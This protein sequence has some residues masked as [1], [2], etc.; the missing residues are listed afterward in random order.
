LIALLWLASAPPLFA[1]QPE[2]FAVSELPVRGRVL[3]AFA[4]RD[5]DGRAWLA[6][7][8]AEAMPPDERRFLTLFARG[9]PAGAVAIPLRAAVAALD[10]AEIG[11]APGPEVVLL[12][13]AQ[14]R[15]L[16]ARGAPLRSIALAPPLPL[17]PRTRE[18]SRLE[19]VGAWSRPAA[20][21]ALLPDVAGF[22]LVSLAPGSGDSRALALPPS[23]IYGEPQPGPPVRP[24]F[25]RA[26]LSWPAVFAVDDDG[27][28]V[29]DLVATTRYAL[30]TYRSDAGGGLS[31]K[32]TRSRRFPPFSFEEERR[33]DSNLMLPALAD[34]DGDGDGDLVVHRTVGTLMGSRAE[35]RVHLNPGGGADPLATP[36]GTLH[37]TGGV[38]TAELRDLD[39]DARAELVQSVL[40][41]GVAQLA[42]ILVRRQAELELRVYGFE[43]EQPGV[44]RLRWSDEMTLPFDFKTARV[45]ALLPKLDG[46]YNGD[47][48]RDLI[49]GDG[50]GNVVLRLG[51][52]GGQFADDALVFPLGATGGAA[53]SA[54]LD[55][56]ALDEIVYWDPVQP[57]GR[58]RVARNR[59]R[60]PGS[61]PRL[62][63]RPR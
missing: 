40:P 62:E 30:T 17:P 54:D 27:D 51:V 7:I 49:Y 16:D 42:R 19:L 22:R 4:A 13:A 60:L 8:S 46:D 41:F 45:T 33:A 3:E 9:E 63:S 15:I 6:A 12:E 18:Q 1:Q 11:G 58:L 26:A 38:G 21:E 55:G 36:A 50:D 24:G 23:A 59:G 61:P 48:L 56:D 34:I 57:T 35:T 44:P 2:L 52:A 32:P 29:R 47:R 5:E 37:V 25:F 10:V 28:G 31:A 14:L 43:P 53:V 39:G 20:R